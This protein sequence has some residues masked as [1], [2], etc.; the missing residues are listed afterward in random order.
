MVVSWEFSS[1]NPHDVCPRFSGREMCG[2]TKLGMF[3]GFWSW[4]GKNLNMTPIKC[5]ETNTECP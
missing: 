5:P 1:P 4:P 2:C 3:G